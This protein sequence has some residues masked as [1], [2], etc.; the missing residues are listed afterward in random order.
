ME[1]V[2]ARPID[3]PAVEL[4]P[5]QVKVKLEIVDYRQE[6]NPGILLA[7]LW[8]R[9]I[10]DV[11]VWAEAG[12]RAEVAGQDRH[13]LV[14]SKALVIWTTP[15]GPAELRAVLERVSPH[16][17]YLFGIDPDLDKPK[18]FLARLAGLVKWALR[19][20]LCQVRISSLAAA[21]AQ[22]E[23]TVRAGLAWLAARGHVTILD[24]TDETD[25]TVGLAPGNQTVAADLSNKSARLQ[26]L[27]EETAAYRA[28]FA[29][30]DGHTLIAGDV[31][32]EADGA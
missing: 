14:H 5:A 22:R 16:T 30:A 31:R 20:E 12:A 7:D 23:G 8:E 17:V 9:E 21:T 13:G 15:P 32:P 29:R 27:L 10:E 24:G 4:R 18:V 3:R 28:F 25:E 1:W 11:Q 6:P 26:V 19:S 2:D